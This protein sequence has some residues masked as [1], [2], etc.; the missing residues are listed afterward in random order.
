[1]ISKKEIK[2]APEKVTKKI[3]KAVRKAKRKRRMNAEYLSEMH[4]KKLGWNPA[5]VSKW[6]PYIRITK[7]LY[8]FIDLLAIEED[9]TV[10][11]IQATSHAN[12][13]ARINKILGHENYAWVKK[14]N[15]IIEVWGWKKT[16]KDGQPN[17]TLSITKL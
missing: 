3:E 9:G 14:T 10:H 2:K 1:M 7:D 15:W 17:Y 6:I 16:I 11:A 8:G 4:A 12:I 13:K 5:N